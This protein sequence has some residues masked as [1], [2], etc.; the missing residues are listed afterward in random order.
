MT[1]CFGSR[2]GKMVRVLTS[3]QCGPGSIPGPEGGLSLLLVLCSE[4]F[5]SRYSG[6]PLSLKTNISKFQFDSG[7]HGHF[8]TS[9]C[10]LLSVLCVNPPKNRASS[11]LL[12]KS[13]RPQVSMGYRLINH[14]GC[15]QNTQRI[16]KPL[17]C[18]PWF[19]NLL[20]FQQHPA[21]FI[22]L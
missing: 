5:L 2:V 18:G 3:Y 12:C 21:W 13:N 15:W 14:L 22:S 9:S 8:S 16:R 20:V 7:M 10:E 19:T 17:T 4:R 11:E 1:I 6:F